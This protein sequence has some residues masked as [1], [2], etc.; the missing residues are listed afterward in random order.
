MRLL[1]GKSDVVS[2][3]HSVDLT[4]PLTDQLTFLQDGEMEPP[5]WVTISKKPPEST[6]LAE[7]ARLS[8]FVASWPNLPPAAY[9]TQ[10]REEVKELSWILPSLLPDKI[11][12]CTLEARFETNTSVNWWTPLMESGPFVVERVP[13][14]APPELLPVAELPTRASITL[15]W[16]WCVE[17]RHTDLLKESSHVLEFCRSA[18]HQTF[19]DPSGVPVNTLGETAFSGRPLGPWREAKALQLCFANFVKN[20]VLFELSEEAISEP[21]WVPALV[22]SGLWDA[23]GE[24]EPESVHLRWRYRAGLSELATTNSTL[25]FSASS[26]PVRTIITMPSTVSLHLEFWPVHRILS[27]QKKKRHLRGSLL[28][29]SESTDTLDEA[30]LSTPRSEA[31]NHHAV[32]GW[33]EMPPVFDN[34]KRHIE[35]EVDH[36]DLLLQG[37]ASQLADFE[38]KLSGTEWQHILWRHYHTKQEEFWDPARLYGES[39]S[40][41]TKTRDVPF[42][43]RPSHLL[44]W[45]VRVSDGLRWSEWSA[46]SP[47]SQLAP[48]IPSLAGPVRLIFNR[49]EPT[50]AKVVWSGCET[51]IE[52]EHLMQ[53]IEYLVFMSID[54][55]S[56]R[57]LIQEQD[58]YIIPRCT[59]DLS[60]GLRKSLP[61]LCVLQE[62]EAVPAFDFES[63]FSEDSQKR[64]LGKF[65][66]REMRTVSAEGDGGPPTVQGFE[67]HVSGLKPHCMHRISVCVRCAVE[68][69]PEPDWQRLKLDPSHPMRW[70]E[71]FHSSPLL[72]PLRPP[73]MLVP[74][75]VPVPDGRFGRFLHTPCI[76]LKCAM[77]A[78][79]NKNDSD[80][81]HSVVVDCRP[82]GST[83]EDYRLVQHSIYCEPVE[84]GPCRLVYNLPFLHA[85]IRTRNITMNDVSAASIPFFAV[86]PLTIQDC[87]GPKEGTLCVRLEWTSR[88]LPAQKPKLLQ[89]GVRRHAVD[90]V[91]A[92]HAS[93]SI[94]PEMCLEELFTSALCTGK[95]FEEL[96][97][98]AESRYQDQS[99]YYCRHCFQPFQRKVS[100]DLPNIG[101]LGEAWIREVPD[102]L[103]LSAVA[104]EE[105]GPGNRVD[106]AALRAPHCIE[107]DHHMREDANPWEAIRK[108][109][110]PCGCRDI[111]CRKDFWDMH[112]DGEQLVHG[113]VYT[114][115][116]RV[117]DGHRWSAWTEYSP[118]MQVVIPP[119]RPPSR[120][121]IREALH[122]E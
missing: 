81:D 25:H 75:L 51:L 46:P 41:C 66:H 119:P 53:S 36:E 52:N 62:G 109:K 76:L 70:S 87:Q 69:L 60:K 105:I 47:A 88:C 21:N 9:S 59:E 73:P 12:R 93:H 1:T 85:E 13:P 120:Q 50:V 19:R 54:E 79:Q 38:R 26:G 16:P 28:S 3:A 31:G 101:P 118:P 37:E 67:L 49:R 90:Q 30:M 61:K 57:E 104:V 112:V 95:D 27:K 40:S 99:P 98:A 83:D 23:E 2:A 43:I 18:A 107:L 97:Q 92:E 8:Q 96:M 44:E 108:A 15:R 35:A 68:N 55:N 102:V 48:P 116:L 29:E 78:K 115:K 100:D 32:T 121:E 103:R 33:I 6:A 5:R 34:I 113:T 63:L 58:G 111:F 84:H 80:K 94:L 39:E 74:E 17:G 114:F 4:K 22:A 56:G 10:L 24:D 89:I 72:T 91:C 42:R 11:F 20:E 71:P 117:S 65:R 110:T 7:T 106:I 122:M 64:L 86:P 45:R 82:A 77:F 14:P